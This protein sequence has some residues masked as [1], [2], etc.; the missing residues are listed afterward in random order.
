MARRA[1][2]PLA[3]LISAALSLGVFALAGG[4]SHAPT[5]RG[6][7]RPAA[8]PSAPAQRLAAQPLAFEPL[9]R[10]GAYLARGTGYALTVGARGTRLTGRGASIGTQL[11]GGRSSRATASKR[12]SMVV[13]RYQGARKNWRTGI[14]TFGRVTYPH[15]YRG[16]DVVYHG[17]GG[18]LEYDFI[19]RPGAD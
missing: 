2:L 6:L 15:V 5:Q 14:P 16:I 8:T 17:R 9:A 18:T 19:V 4:S 3:A 13:N 10:G 7:D 12:Q 1:P 11:V